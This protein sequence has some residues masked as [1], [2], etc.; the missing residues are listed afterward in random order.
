MFEFLYITLIQFENKN[1]NRLDFFPPNVL[2]HL[3]ADIEYNQRKEDITKLNKLS[4]N[5][6]GKRT[7]QKEK[8]NI[9]EVKSK[10]TI[11]KFLL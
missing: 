1:L 6:R 10:C 8:K 9:T 7:K 5:T 2:F 3:P 11:N 4:P